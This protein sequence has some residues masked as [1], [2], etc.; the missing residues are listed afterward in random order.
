[1]STGGQVTVDPTTLGKIGS[2]LQTSAAIV[3]GKTADVEGWTFGPGQ[4]GRAYAAEGTK[5]AGGIGR[6]ATWLKSWQTAVDKTGAQLSS[7]AGTYASVD[8]SNVKRIAAAAVDL[9]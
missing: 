8:D 3:G 1:M 5:V 7:S 4:A 2:N 6:V 9:G